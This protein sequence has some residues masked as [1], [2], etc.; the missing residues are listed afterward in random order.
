MLRSAQSLRVS[1]CGRTADVQGRGVRTFPDGSW[2]EGDHD[3]GE[4]TGRGTFRAANGDVYEGSWL[5]NSREGAASVAESA[6][7]NPSHRSRVEFGFYWR[8]C[9]RS[10]GGEPPVGLAWF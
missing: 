5:A 8:V 2:Y 10:A 7:W 6:K 4:R 1:V 9:W 3:Q